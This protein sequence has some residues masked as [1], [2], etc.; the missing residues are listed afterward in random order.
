MTGRGLVIALCLGGGSCGAAARSIALTPVNAQTTS[1]LISV[2]CTPAGRVYAVDA[3]GTAHDLDG[4]GARLSWDGGGP[5]ARAGQLLFQVSGG[6][7]RRSDDGGAHWTP[8]QVP[9]PTD[10]SYGRGTP[11]AVAVG[12]GG[13]P[14]F[15]LG[16]YVAISN[17][18]ESSYAYLARS[19][20]G[21]ASWSRPWTG[22]DEGPIG[23]G[24]RQGPDVA[25][26]LAVLPGGAVALGGVDGSVL[27]SADGGRTFQ[28]RRSPVAQPIRA[29]W[30]ARDGVLYGV[31]SHGAIVVSTDRGRSFRAVDSHVVQDLAAIT[32]C[33]DHV[34]LVGAGGTALR[35]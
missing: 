29:L 9:A 14:L 33:R 1:D 10:V 27:I 16:R 19:P 28:A 24:R 30:T 32:G 8:L 4:H 31:G 21:G 3:H 20:D 34:W 7:L 23:M 22:P 15:V 12:S 25:A 35:E 5:V 26:T 11:V 17:S 2:W 13:S 18:L 6:Q